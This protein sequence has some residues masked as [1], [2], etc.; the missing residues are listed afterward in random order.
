MITQKK[1]Y[2][3]YF[4]F[5]SDILK[6][7]PVHKLDNVT[8]SQRLVDN[9]QHHAGKCWAALYFNANVYR[10]YYSYGVSC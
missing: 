2:P 4:T 3:F 10:L 1:V 9:L 5:I 8:A 6:G 7:L